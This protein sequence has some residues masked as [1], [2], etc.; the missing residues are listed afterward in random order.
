[1]GFPGPRNGCD[2]DARRVHTSHTGQQTGSSGRAIV[3]IMVIM[4]KAEQNVIQVIAYRQ[5]GVCIALL[6]PNLRT[7]RLEVEYG[8]LLVDAHR[9]QRL[10]NRTCV[11]KLAKILARIIAVFGQHDVAIVINHIA[12]LCVVA[13]RFDVTIDALST[14]RINVQILSTKMFPFTY[15]HFTGDLHEPVVHERVR[16][17]KSHHAARRLHSAIAWENGMRRGHL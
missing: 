1:M 15:I 2:S 7:M 16:K 4:N 13:A 17:L 3:A 10:H 6:F 9:N 5:Q 12:V 11:I 14:Q 8:Q